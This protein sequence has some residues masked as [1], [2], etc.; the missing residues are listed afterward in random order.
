MLYYIFYN[1]LGYLDFN[2][3]DEL[4]SDLESEEEETEE[5]PNLKKSNK[6]KGKFEHFIFFISLIW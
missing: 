3:D 5:T 1:T 2:E 6:E 4:F